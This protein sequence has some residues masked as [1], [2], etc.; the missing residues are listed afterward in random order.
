[1]QRTNMVT[2]E[3]VEAMARMVDLNLSEDRLGQV[4]SLLNDWIPNAAD[5]SEKMREPRYRAVGP[6]TVFAHST[7]NQPAEWTPNDD[8]F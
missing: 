6:I 7:T 5:L 4:A 8:Q 2:R 3:T 1:M